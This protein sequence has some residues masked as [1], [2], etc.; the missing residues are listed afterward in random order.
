VSDH[1]EAALLEICVDQL[2]QSPDWEH[3]TQVLERPRPDFKKLLETCEARLERSGE[4]GRAEAEA[5]TAKVERAVRI[6]ASADERRQRMRRGRRR[7]KP[8]R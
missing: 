7:R 5:M 8:D 6:E 2:L 3:P 4:Q 1:G